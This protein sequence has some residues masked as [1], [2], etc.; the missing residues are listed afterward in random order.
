MLL[1]RTSDIHNCAGPKRTGNDC[2]KLALLRMGKRYAASLQQKE[3]SLSMSGLMRFRSVLQLQK[4]GK[5]T[6]FAHHNSSGKR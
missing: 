6:A 5:L 4:F 1:I 2:R 3:L